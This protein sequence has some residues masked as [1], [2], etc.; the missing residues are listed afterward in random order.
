MHRTFILL[1]ALLLC[2]T[3]CTGCAGLSGMKAWEKGRYFNSELN[4]SYQPDQIRSIGIY[5][6]SE[7]EAIDGSEKPFDAMELVSSIILFPIKLFSGTLTFGAPQVG[8]STKFYPSEVTATSVLEPD[9]SNSGPSLELAQAIREQLTQRG[10]SATV[11]TELGHSREIPVTK[12]LDHA[13]ANGYDAALVVNYSGLSKW[14]EYAGTDVQYGYK[15]KTVITKV[16]V[17]EGFL[18]LPNAVMFSTASNDV[19]W[20]NSF[21]GVYENAHVMNLSGEPFIKAETS[22]MLPLGDDS[23]FK[24]A[25]KAAESLFDPKLWRDSFREF[26]QRG[27]KKRKL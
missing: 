20:S 17:Y 24:A 22:A 4:S 11:V 15:T 2:A 13:K 3:L 26:P 10:Y 21:Y 25:P 5:V 19:L 6:Y 12:C 23:Y 7:G 18:Y 27:E 9:T 8:V 1:G 16:N 14:T